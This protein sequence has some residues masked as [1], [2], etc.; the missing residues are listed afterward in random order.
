MGSDADT[1]L[2][3]KTVAWW[4]TSIIDIEPGKIGIRGHP[5]QELIGS[6]SFVEMIWLML[7]GSRPTPQHCALLEAALV[8][9]VDHGPHA[10]SIAIARMSMTCGVELNTAVASATGVLGDVHGGAGQLCMT[11]FDLVRN[12]PDA[13][14]NLPDAVDRVLTRFVVEHG[15]IVPGYGHRFH[16]IDPRT[17]PLLSMVERAAKSGHVSGRYAAIGREVE[18]G[19]RRRTGKP[20]P[21]NIDGATAVIFSELGFA[22]PL[23]RGLFILSRS[24]GILAHAWEQFQQGGR[25]KGPMPREIPYTYSGPPTSSGT[26]A[27]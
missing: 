10:P 14:E 16:P 15:R 17:E 12:E 1:E 27:D 11:L 2:L 20:I 6:V 4:T 9:S 19:I 18:A 22:P 21:M 26:S 3:R 5:I 7:R 24:V 13:A 8:A 25:N 23:G